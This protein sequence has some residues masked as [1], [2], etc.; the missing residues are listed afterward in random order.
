MKKPVQVYV[1]S[2]L[3]ACRKNHLNVFGN[4][5]SSS[6]PSPPQLNIKRVAVPP[7]PPV[8]LPQL[9]RYKPKCDMTSELFS[10]YGNPC[11]D[12]FYDVLPHGYI[13]FHFRDIK[14]P[15]SKIDMYLKQLLP[16]HPKTLACNLPSIAAG[17]FGSLT[18][19]LDILSQILEGQDRFFHL[20]LYSEIEKP[21]GFPSPPA[22]SREEIL[23][24]ARKAVEMYQ[25]D[26]NYLILH[27]GQQQ[28]INDDDEDETSAAECLEITSA[29][30][31]CPDFDSDFNR[32]TLLCES[33]AKK[34]FPRESYPEYLGVEE[35]DYTDRVRQRLI[36]EVL[37]PLRK[38]L[39]DC[40]LDE[41]F[42][43]WGYK[44][45]SKREPCAVK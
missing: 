34:V 12:L 36:K 38:A 29:G 28:S 25:C 19:A 21:P 2:V 17:S 45:E 7:P 13:E 33:I 20:D 18:T 41:D 43:R 11:L 24:W 35:S 27:D 26:P 9:S 5:S 42:N 14:R 10:S 1:T 22:P 23:A 32:N 30:L 16:N 31:S 6:S 4:T 40:D 44:R 37:V 39:E 3:K 8:A 15:C